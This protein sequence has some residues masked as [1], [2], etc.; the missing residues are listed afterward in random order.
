VAKFRIWLQGIKTTLNYDNAEPSNTTQFI[1]T[2]CSLPLKWLFLLFLVTPEGKATAS[3]ICQHNY[4]TSACRPL[5]N[6]CYGT[7]AQIFPHFNFEVLYNLHENTS[8]MMGK[9]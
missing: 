3:A 7:K 4:F 5:H 2:T 1:E 6:T 9:K 8:Y